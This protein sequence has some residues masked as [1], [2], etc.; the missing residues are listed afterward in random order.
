MVKQILTL[1]AIM[2]LAL[3]MAPTNTFAE[4][5]AASNDVKPI[6]LAAVTVSHPPLYNPAVHDHE[7]R[8]SSG[9]TYNKYVQF[10]VTKRLGFLQTV[11]WHDM[12]LCKDS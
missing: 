5:S 8:G 9:M 4:D 1:V 10:V 3:F 6:I 7:F 12:N 2:A 11:S